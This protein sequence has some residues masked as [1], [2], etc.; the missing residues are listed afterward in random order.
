MTQSD[1]RKRFELIDTIRGI[2]IINMVAYHFLWDLV[3]ICGFNIKWYNSSFGYIWQQFICWTFIFIS[4]FSYNLGK[5]KLKRGI[6]ALL[7]GG[8]VTIVTLIFTPSSKIVFGILT[9]LGSSII[10]TF[11]LEKVISKIP[12]ILGAIFSF[13]IFLFTKNCSSGYLGFKNILTIR[14]PEVIYRNN[15]T[16]Y[17]GFPNPS[18]NSSDYFPMIPWLFL[19]FTGFFF[20]RVLKQKNLLEKYFLR[21]KTP[22]ISFLG[23]NSLIIYLIHQPILYGISLLIMLFN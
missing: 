9:L 22:L 19:F 14:I 11:L 18:F 17:L 15:L 16:A 1:S 20:F 7:G 5:H 8:I 23:K 3:F 4:G 2:A 21:G 10:I 12:S 6:L 13:T